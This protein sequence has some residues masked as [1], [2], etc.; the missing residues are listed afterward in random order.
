MNITLG[1]RTVHPGFHT[2]E[3]IVSVLTV[4]W[5]VLNAWQDWMSNTGAVTLSAPAVAF[6]LSRGLAKYEQR[7]PTTPP[8]PPQA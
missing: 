3:F 4:A 2:S 5:Y 6:I 1:T 8:A 7:G